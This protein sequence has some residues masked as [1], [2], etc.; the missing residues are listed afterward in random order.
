MSEMTPETLTVHQRGAI[1][2]GRYAQSSVRATW[3][4][5]TS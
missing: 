1:K 5:H 3:R 4:G 2:M